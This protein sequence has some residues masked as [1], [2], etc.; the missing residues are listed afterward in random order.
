VDEYVRVVAEAMPAGFIFENVPSLAHPS[1]RGRLDRLLEAASS[2][3]YSTRVCRLQAVEHGAPQARLRLFVLGLAGATPPSDVR[4]THWWRAD[5]QRERR[6]LQPPETVGNWISALDG[7]GFAEAD[8]RPSGKWQRQLL[9]VPPGMNYKFH[10][11]W[12]GHPE[13]TFVTETKYW[14][15]LLKLHPNRPSWTLQASP[16]PWTGPFHWT[17]RRLR[18]PEV[19]ALQTFPPTYRFE[20]LRRSQWRQIG[21]A[22]PPLL[23]SRV[24]ASLLADITGSKPHSRRRLRYRLVKSF[25]F[26]EERFGGQSHPTR[27]SQW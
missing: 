18:I 7:D 25:P 5:T 8:E 6:R 20:G 21:N 22:V 13:P 26:D 2:L 14:S 12:A 11:A 9:E 15:F 24:A 23:A 3:G 17:G 19:A 10:S 1:H 4:V 27:G 16:G